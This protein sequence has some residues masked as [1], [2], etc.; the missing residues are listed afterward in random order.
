MKIHNYKFA[1]VQWTHKFSFLMQANDLPSDI[2]N[3]KHMF[4]HNDTCMSAWSSIGI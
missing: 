3:T 2:L 1:Y 4:V